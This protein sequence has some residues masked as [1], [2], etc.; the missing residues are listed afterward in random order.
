[1]SAAD[2]LNFQDFQLPQSLTQPMP[3]TLASA[4]TIAPT[5]LITIVS[6]VA[7][8]VNITPPFAGAHMLILI[9]SGA[10]TMTAAGNIATAVAANVA[11]QI[12]FAIYNP[13]TKKY[14]VGKTAI[15]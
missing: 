14:Y 6:G 2:T 8:I 15:G 13:A 12:T 7:A 10:W 5:T 11:G 1:M 9:A 3:T 4:A